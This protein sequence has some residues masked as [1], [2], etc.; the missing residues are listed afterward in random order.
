MTIG[1]DDKH[2]A[3]TNAVARHSIKTRIVPSPLLI[4]YALVALSLEVADALLLALSDLEA[5]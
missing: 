1:R 3:K 4:A 5:A 2:P